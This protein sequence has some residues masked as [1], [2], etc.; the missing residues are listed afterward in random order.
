M[1]LRSEKKLSAPA[2]KS[3]WLK[4]DPDPGKPTPGP[5]VAA[6]VLSAKQKG[7]A[8]LTANGPSLSL[9]VRRVAYVALKRHPLK[10]S[11]TPPEA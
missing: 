11:P 7:R 4:T 2:S 9:S 1:C 8:C 5:G 3:H 6:P 10:L